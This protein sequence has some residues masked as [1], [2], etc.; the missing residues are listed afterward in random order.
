MRRTSFLTVWKNKFSKRSA[1]HG[2]SPHRV[3][4]FRV[5]CFGD[6]HAYLC[7]MIKIQNFRAMMLSCHIGTISILTDKEYIDVDISTT[8]KDYLLSERYYATD[9]K[10]LLYDLRSL[11]EQTMR[12]N[13]FSLLHVWFEVYV[14]IL[15]DHSE[16]YDRAGFKVIYCDRDID[17]YDF[18]PLLKSHFLTAAASRRVAPESFVFL[19]FFTFNG[20]LVNYEIFVDYV[21]KGASGHC[22]FAGPY[23]QSTASSDGVWTHIIFCEEIQRQAEDMVGAEIEL[24]AFTVRVG[25]RAA[26]FFIDK[27]LSGTRPFYFRNCFNVPDNLFVPAV[28]TAKT[29]VDRSLAV[30]GTVSQFYDATCEQTYEVQS[31][32]L[33]ADECSLGEQMFCSDDVRTPYESAP[34]DGD[35][36]ALRPVLITDST[37]EIADDPEKPNTV[38]FA[39]RY[40]ENRIAQRNPLGVGIFTEP[41]DY[42]FR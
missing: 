28:T 14:D 13:G 37:S 3:A 41:Y 1:S 16:D 24:T 21:L 15:D 20:E 42:T 12:Q 36:D 40:T 6:L 27:S 29:K 10:V 35:F 17:I 26:S 18:E 32:G 30:L 22:W 38:K 11:L 31:A 4:A 25:D 9:G 2:G 8:E 39:W 5:F 19:P 7:R 34:D 23:Q 33:T